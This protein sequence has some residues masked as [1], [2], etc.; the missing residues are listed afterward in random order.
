MSVLKGFERIGGSAKK[1]AGEIFSSTPFAFCAFSLIPIL[2][3][4]SQKYHKHTAMGVSRLLGNRL[5]T[6]ILATIALFTIRQLYW[7]RTKANVRSRGE[8]LHHD[9]LLQQKEQ[10]QQ[11]LQ[12]QQKVH[13]HQLSN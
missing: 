8:Q 5:P 12:L 1:G 9:N 13:S 3:K 4:N 10:L 7:F 2:S 6:A 11:D